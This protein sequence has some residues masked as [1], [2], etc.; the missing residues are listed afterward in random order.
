MSAH[1]LAFY[2]LTS[3][4]RFMVISFNDVPALTKMLGPDL[5]KFKGLSNRIDEVLAD[6][7]VRLT[8]ALNKG[9]V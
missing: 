6:V 3:L 4:L 9:G 5:N 2:C 8:T 1:S 7:D